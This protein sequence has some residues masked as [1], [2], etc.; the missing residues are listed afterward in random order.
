MKPFWQSKTFWFNVLALVVAVAGAFGFAGFRPSAD[1]EQ[2]A[3]V[4]VVLINLVLRFVTKQ[5]VGLRASDN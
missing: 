4:L 1:T 5:P 2:L 3:Y